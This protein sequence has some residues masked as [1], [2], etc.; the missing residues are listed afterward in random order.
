MCQTL[1]VVLKTHRHEIPDPEQEE[2]TLQGHMMPVTETSG[3][4]GKRNH[5]LDRG[6][7]YNAY[8]K[9]GA[10]AGQRRTPLAGTSEKTDGAENNWT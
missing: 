2:H 10:V 6:L 5:Y 1:S 9:Q 4:A 7:N 3:C 8:Y